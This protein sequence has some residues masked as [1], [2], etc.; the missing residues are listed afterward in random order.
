VKLEKFLILSQVAHACD[1]AVRRMSIA[2]NM[3][4]KIDCTVLMNMMGKIESKTIMIIVG[5]PM[6][7][8]NSYNDI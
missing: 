5:E 7:K 8:R 6:E 4:V 2:G 3:T 1:L